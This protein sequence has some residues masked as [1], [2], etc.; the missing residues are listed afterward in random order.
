MSDVASTR[1]TSRAIVTI[2]NNA[3][4][5]PVATLHTTGKRALR[6]RYSRHKWLSFVANQWFLVGDD[7]VSPMH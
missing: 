7:E 1:T 4:N 5:E 3:I 2:N 6:T